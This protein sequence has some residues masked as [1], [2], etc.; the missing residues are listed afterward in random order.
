MNLRLCGVETEYAFTVTNRHGQSLNRED[1]LGTVLA[2]A[3]RELV[4]LPA[5]KG[6]GMF[7][8]NGSRFYVDCGLHPEWSTPECLDPR[9]VVR[10]IRAGERILEGICARLESAHPEVCEAACYNCNVDYSGS[11]STWGCHE[12]YLHRWE[13]DML[14]A[15]LIPHLVSRVIYTGAGGFNRSGSK[16]LDFTLSPRVAHLEEQV[17]SGSTGNRGIFHTKDEPLC[18]EGFHRL[19]IICGESL[20]SDRAAWLKLG[21]TA[22]VVAMAEA[23]LAPARMVTLASPLKA[24][25]TFAADVT[26][27]AEVSMI[28]RRRMTAVAIQREYLEQA[29]AHLSQSW[30][31][32]WAGDVCQQWRTMLDQIDDG[33]EGFDRTLDWAIKYRIYARHLA[34]HGI[35]LESQPDWRRVN[36]AIR[37]AVKQ[38]EYGDPPPTVEAAMHGDGPYRKFIDRIDFPALWG[39]HSREEFQALLALRMELFELD[40][41]WGQVGHRGIFSQLD[42]GDTLDHRVS[43]IDR[44]DDA[45]T[46]PPSGTRAGVRGD[47]IRRLASNGGGAADW[48]AVWTSKDGQDRFLD[49][50]N[51]FQT[52]EGWSPSARRG[53]RLSTRGLLSADPESFLGM[54]RRRRPQ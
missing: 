50:S 37:E 54:L 20:A 45:M 5:A 43:G 11:G 33:R 49:L 40:T 16:L 27:S 46:K 3:R 44:V 42:V 36:Q 15:Q 17:S 48:S 7:T 53:K 30:M 52:T 1:M 41:R 2:I 29:E 14:P 10:H 32:S 38:A 23:G 12:S 19:H 4:H 24:M 13:P 6:G 34:G 21:T 22:I 18:G 26:C 47:A 9:D 39:G 31:P 8:E 28:D 35:A 51:P 25:R